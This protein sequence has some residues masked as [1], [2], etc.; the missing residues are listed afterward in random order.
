[1]INFTFIKI[2]LIAI[3]F[4]F[5]EAK[6]CGTIEIDCATQAIDGVVYIR[7]SVAPAYTGVS[8]KHFYLF[9]SVSI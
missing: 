1:M 6:D 3:V 2:A 9:C 7:G 4:S 8:G 5:V